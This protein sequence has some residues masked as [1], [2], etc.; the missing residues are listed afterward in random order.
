MTWMVHS[1]TGGR[2]DSYRAKD[3]LTQENIELV[4]E[5]HRK[6]GEWEVLLDIDNVVLVWRWRGKSDVIVYVRQP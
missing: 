1:H 5:S 4:R 6:G 3:R 2:P